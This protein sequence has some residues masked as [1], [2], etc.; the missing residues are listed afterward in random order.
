[1]S[2]NKTKGL[3]DVVKIATDALGIE[4]CEGCVQRQE[5]LNNLIPFGE[6]DTSISDADRGVLLRLK[7]KDVKSSTDR[8]YLF[9]LYNRV[10]KD[11]LKVC[12]CQDQ[13]NEMIEKLLTVNAE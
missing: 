12:Q 7:N 13:I 2:K 9:S 4:Q 6:N 1:M 10:F 3:G 11:N 8:H 5:L